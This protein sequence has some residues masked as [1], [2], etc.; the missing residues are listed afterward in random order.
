MGQDEKKSQV[1]GV[2]ECA[3]VAITFDAVVNVLA[4]SLSGG[5]CGF[6]DIRYS[7][8]DYCKARQALINEGV[9]D[10]CIE[11]VQAQ[12][13]LMKLPIQ[14]HMA[15]E[16]RDEEWYDLTIDKLMEGIKK[17]SL[18]DH[19]EGKVWDVANQ[20]PDCKMDF[21]DYDAILQFA[22]YG[23]DIIG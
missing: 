18:S 23:E 10:P 13:L 17:Y 15:E 22:C 14:L 12:M 4:N 6:D 20:D 3:P 11:E 5:I 21:Y 1:L 8:D 2:V 7:Q 19:Y 16:R 9:E